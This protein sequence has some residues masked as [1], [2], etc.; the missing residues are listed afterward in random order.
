MKFSSPKALSEHI[1]EI[2]FFF[3]IVSSL[4]CFEILGSLTKKLHL[5]TSG[6]EFKVCL[7]M[8]NPELFQCS[9]IL[10][11]INRHL[12]FILLHWMFYIIL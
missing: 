10:T 5:N 12:H 7:L 9:Q 1:Q 3:N 6:C 2:V 8:S 11:V 4:V